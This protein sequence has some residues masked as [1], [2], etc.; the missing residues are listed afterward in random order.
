LNLI[1]LHL[2]ISVHAKVVAVSDNI[3]LRHEEAL[4]C[5]FAS[6]LTL[7]GTCA[8]VGSSNAYELR[9]DH[10]NERFEIGR[11]VG[12]T[13]LL[14]ADVRANFMAAGGASRLKS[15]TGGDMLEA[16]RK[17][18][19]Q[20]FY[21]EGNFNVILTSNSRLRVRLEGDTSAWKR[22]LTIARDDKPFPGKKIPEIH[23]R[24]LRTEGSGIL[25]WFLKGTRM[26]LEDIA[27]YGDIALSDRQI[28]HVTSLLL[29]SDSL[30]IF[31]KQN[32]SRAA[33]SDLAVSELVENYMKFCTDSGWSPIP[34]NVVYRQL[35]DILLEL[36]AVSNPTA[37][38]DTAQKSAATVTSN[39]DPLMM[40]NDLYKIQLPYLC[41]ETLRLAVSHSENLI[42]GISL[43]RS[44][45]VR[46]WTASCVNIGFGPMKP[47]SK[48]LGLPP[49]EPLNPF[50]DA[51]DA[52]FPYLFISV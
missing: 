25:N 17:G 14:G 52:F 2:A 46:L 21:V 8:V 28:D 32:V 27:Q 48:S 5:P 44:L 18:S 41:R 3:R 50:W 22:R 16:E 12:K 10:L 36:F 11:M 26:L 33:G 47:K 49:T 23:E 39:S 30:R 37:F 20:T 29:E 19:N 51:W 35:D 7:L 45:S 31:I 15:L 38:N 1:V 24:L 13:L 6:K 34:V 40:R 4:L 42:D 43:N 9:T